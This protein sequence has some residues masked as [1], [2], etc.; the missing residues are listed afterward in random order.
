MQL[1]SLSLALTRAGFL[2]FSPASLFAAGEQGAWYDP[3]DM[4]T[5]FQDSAGTTP[6]TA[7]DQPVGLMLDK[8]G[9]GNHATQTTTTKRP[10]LKQDGNGKYYLLFDGVDDFMVTNSI[11]FTST[12]KMTVWAGVRKLSD[13]ATSIIAEHGNLSA[14]NTTSMLLASSNA[15]DANRRSYA[16]IIRSSAGIQEAA[17]GIA[18]YQ[19][20]IS[21]VVS[22]TMDRSK[23]T[24]IEEI[25][26]R[27]NGQAS[28]GVV[29]SNTNPTGNFANYPLYIG[30]RGGTTLQFNGRIYSLIIRGAQ[31]STEQITQT[32]SWVNGKTGAY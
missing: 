17:V 4:S 26:M 29:A 5:L 21:S 24:A 19:A 27:H 13:A 31:S 2:S 28:T 10:L 14:D 12:D 25:V 16:S 23:I 15:Y 7:V 9:R 8:S 18:P 30:C 20:P 32:E 11:D 6:V 22:I 1:T 3:S